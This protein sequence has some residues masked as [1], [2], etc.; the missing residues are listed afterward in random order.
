MIELRMPEKVLIVDDEP[1]IL[2][3]MKRALERQGYEI[4]AV[5]G[6]ADAFGALQKSGFSL[7]VMDLHL[8]GITTRE[9]KEH[10]GRIA[11][12]TKVIYVSGSM[13]KEPERNF[14][15]KPFTIEDLRSLAKKLLD[16]TR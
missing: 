8:G 9:L 7:I 12:E 10:L 4:T 2:Q 14:L 11:P 15:L 16:E 1:L 3:S 5:A 6:W 13:P